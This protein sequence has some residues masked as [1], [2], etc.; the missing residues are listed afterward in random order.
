MSPLVFAGFVA[1]EVGAFF[2]GAALSQTERGAWIAI[3]SPFAA[4]LGVSALLHFA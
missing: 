4:F 3:C 1:W 2:W